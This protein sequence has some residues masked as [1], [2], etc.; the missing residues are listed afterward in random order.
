MF[1]LMWQSPFSIQALQYSHDFC[2]IRNGVGEF[3]R[4]EQP[5]GYK[6]STFHRV[7]KVSIFAICL[8]G[9]VILSAKRMHQSIQS[10]DFMIQGEFG[11]GMKLNIC[12]DLSVHDL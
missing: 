7:I 2:C 5:T 1:G 10:Q 8:V 9:L 4:N 12:N 3:L 11:N 6:E